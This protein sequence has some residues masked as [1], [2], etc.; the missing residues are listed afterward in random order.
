MREINPKCLPLIRSRLKKKVQNLSNERYLKLFGFPKL[1]RDMLCSSSS[2]IDEDLFAEIVQYFNSVTMGTFVLGRQWTTFVSNIEIAVICFVDMINRSI[3]E[4]ISIDVLHSFNDLEILISTFVTEVPKY[5]IELLWLSGIEDKSQFCIITG[6][7]FLFHSFFA[8]LYR[9][10]YDN[11]PQNTYTQP[12]DKAIVLDHIRQFGSL[13]KFSDFSN[14]SRLVPE[15]KEKVSMMDVLMRLIDLGMYEEYCNNHPVLQTTIRY[16]SAS[17][18]RNMLASNV[19][20]KR[21]KRPV[22]SMLPSEIESLK[23]AK[24]GKRPHSGGRSSR[25]GKRLKRSRSR[26]KRP[27]STK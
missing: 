8:H 19:E 3:N 10:Y 7:L 14:Y 21:K 25:S 6:P 2:F 5:L 17:K 12:L 13:T 26:I 1:L 4:A 16:V 27:S 20:V 24:T 9:L 15:S 23:P 22:S 18:L 11:F